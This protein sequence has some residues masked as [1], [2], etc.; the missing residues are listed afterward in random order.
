MD[1]FFPSCRQKIVVRTPDCFSLL[2]LNNAGLGR[3]KIV[4]QD[5]N[6]DHAHIRK[7]LEEQYPELKTQNGAFQFLR[8]ELGGSGLRN[9]KVIDMSM[10]RIHCFTF[11]ECLQVF[12]YIY[13]TTK[14]EHINAI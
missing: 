9:L 13:S 8:C 3:K 10:Q 2:E 7:T 12:I 6:G 1:P 14:H 5:K 11:E 4:F